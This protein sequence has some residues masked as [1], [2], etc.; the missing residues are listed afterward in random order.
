[1]YTIPFDSDVLKSII[2]GE[3]SSP[4]IDYVNSKIKGKNFITYLSNLKYDNLFIDFSDVS[5]EEKSVIISEFIKHNSTCHIEQLEATVIKCLFLYRGY[6]LSLLDEVES[7]TK[8]LEKSILNNQELQEYL[9]NNKNLIKQLADILDGVLLYA[10]KNINDYKEEVGNDI[11]SNIVV[12]KQE[13]GKTFVN[14]LDNVSF[15]FHY[16]SSLPSFEEL[17]YFEHYFDRPIYSGKTLINYIITPNCFIYPML[18][19]I[20]GLEFSPE[21][22]NNIIKE[23]DATLI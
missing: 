16:Y 14:I 1:M 15:N 13:I 5:F 21:Q 9:D 6:D 20:L 12:E 23:A 19:M 18:K 3:I 17:K 10:I 7:D 8:T 22:L 4:K 11:T 2:T